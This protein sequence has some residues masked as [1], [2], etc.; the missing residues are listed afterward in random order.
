[1]KN[2]TH[3]KALLE[4]TPY[5]MI[6]QE[7]PNLHNAHAWGREIY[8]KIKQGDKLQSYAKSARRI[9]HTAQSNSHCIYWPDSQRLPLN[10]MFYLLFEIKLVH[11]QHN[12]PLEIYSY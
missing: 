2:H 4:R 12:K 6:H 10:R 8:V 11:L 5:E 1:M 3:T 7:K 9:G